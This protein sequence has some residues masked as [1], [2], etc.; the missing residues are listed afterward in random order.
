MPD[1]SSAIGDDNRGHQIRISFVLDP[2]V[3]SETPEGDTIEVPSDP[4]A[5]PA[6]VRRRGLSAII[7]HLLDRKVEPEKGGSDSDEGL[8]VG[9]TA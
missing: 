4:I 1:A 6:T 5:V 7:N 8:R 3:E 9:I 2:S